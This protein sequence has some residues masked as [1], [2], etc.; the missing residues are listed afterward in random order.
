M[1]KKIIICIAFAASILPSGYALAQGN[2][3]KTDSETTS[4]KLKSLKLQKEQIQKKIS[5]EDGK[6]NK[7][8]AGVAEETLERMNEKQDSICLSLRSKLTNINLEIKRL[9]Q[10]SISPELLNQFDNIINTH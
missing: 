7:Q 8:I 4:L 1:K 10:T 3:N 9:T 5:V 6:R 2:A